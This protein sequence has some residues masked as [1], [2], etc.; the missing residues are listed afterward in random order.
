MVVSGLPNMTPIFM[1]IWLMKMTRVLDRL[2]FPVSLR[3]AWDMSLAWSPTCESPISPSISALGVRAATESMTTTS[4][5]PER[6]RGVG[7]LE[8]LLAR[9]RL[10][11]Q[12]VVDVEADLL[13]VP[14]IEGVLGVDER[15]GAALALRLRDHF[16]GQGGLAGRFRPVDLHHPA[17]RQ[18][19]DAEGGIEPE[20]AVGIASMSRGTV[21]SPRRMIVPRPN[22]RSS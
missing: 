3:S 12:Q 7:D 20:R 21:E 19:P 8:G 5:A 2:M 14:G 6:T 18:P 15:R 22:C 1:R 4:T 11:D 10:R 16:Q 13:R 9:V 17:A